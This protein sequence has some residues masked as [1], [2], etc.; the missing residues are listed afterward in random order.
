MPA[1]W[2][3]E[4][5]AERQVVKEA[6]VSIVD[7]LKEEL[8]PSLEFGSWIVNAMETGEP[9]VIH[10]NVPNRGLIDN[11]PAGSCVE[12][13]CLV[14]KNGVQPTR[15]GALPP[16]CAALNRTNINVQE[17]AVQAVVTGNKEHIY[18]A[19]ALDPLTGAL[20]TLDEIRAMTDELFAANAS[21]LPVH[22]R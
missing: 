4:E 3:Y 9:T 8:K 20:L 1:R 6:D 17:L 22:W 18:Q 19:I 2:E 12:V 7:Q 13:A 10:G 16:Q 21:Y 5:V 15:Y 11:L 14:D